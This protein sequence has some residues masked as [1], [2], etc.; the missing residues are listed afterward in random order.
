MKNFFGIRLMVVALVTIMGLGVIFKP[1]VTLAQ[2]PK[3]EE[4]YVTGPY[5]VLENLKVDGKAVKEEYRL[6]KTLDVAYGKVYKF[7]QISNGYDIFG[8]ELAVSV[9]SE[10]KVLSVLGDY[11]SIPALSGNLSEGEAKSIVSQ[12]HSGAEVLSAEKK[13]YAYNHSPELAYDILVN[14]N[15]GLR[16]FVSAESGEVL[17]SCAANLSYLMSKQ[18][19]V[20]GNEVEVNLEYV[21][22]ED[23]Y[24]LGDDLRNIYVLDGQN[25]LNGGGYNV[26]NSTGQFEPLAITTYLNVV[27]TYDFYADANNIGVSLK[28]INGRNDDIL[29]NYEENDEVPIF[30]VVHYGDKYENLAGQYDGEFGRVLVGDG[31]A[32]GDIYQPGRALDVIGHEYQHIITQY[33]VDLVYEGDSGALNEAISDILGA[34]IEGHDMSEDEFWMIAEDVMQN[35][36][37]ALRSMKIKTGTADHRYSMD[38]KYVCTI[39]HSHSAYGNNCDSNGVHINSTIISHIQY[40]LYEQMPQYF[41]KERI[42]ALW[43]ATLCNLTSTATFE[44]FAF[45]FLQSASN[46]GFSSEALNAIYTT[47]KNG[48]LLPSNARKVTFVYDDDTVMA[49]TWVRDG[50]KVTYPSNPQREET[51]QYYYEFT[52]WDSAPETVTSDITIKANFTAVLRSYTVTLISGGKAYS[53]QSIKYGESMELPKLSSSDAPESDK[54]FGGWYHDAECTIK[55]QS[56]VRITGDV[57]FYAK[58]EDKKS[59]CGTIVLGDVGGTGLMLLSIMALLCLTVIL[60]H[61]KKVT[62]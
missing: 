4:A 11:L 30:V 1:S 41:T 7:I 42:G 38:D 3:A 35:G 31:N 58:W 32:K 40:L 27:K 5:S 36:Q 16:Y 33:F 10:G 18:T 25:T 49:E 24:Y 22:E 23:M 45:A 44:D 15:G 2:T 13:I 61:K 47:L 17:L 54:S 46:L 9:D 12:L 60:T 28:G 56:S 8:S 51:A 21:A 50:S 43:Y 19:D 20:E 53:T 14:A 39:N 26:K 62:E 48:K 34:L 6:E 57:S 52:G 29:N 37:P 59:G 55:A